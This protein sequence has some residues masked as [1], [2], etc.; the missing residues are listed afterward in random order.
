[1]DVKR[2][3]ARCRWDGRLH[4][5]H[6]LPSLT[7]ADAETIGQD[8]EGATERKSR[9]HSRLGGQAELGD[10]VLDGRALV[11]A[12]AVVVAR[13][14]VGV[15]LAQADVVVAAGSDL[16]VVLRDAG[17]HDAVGRGQCGSDGLWL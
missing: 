3:E 15:V 8:K 14:L 4:N 7:R 1:M 10:L 5:I 17:V 12:H 16:L 9:A 2:G 13:E 11:A 6:L